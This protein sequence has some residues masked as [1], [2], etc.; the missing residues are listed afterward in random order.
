MV[1]CTSIL[2]QSFF[3]IAIATCTSHEIQIAMSLFKISFYNVLLLEDTYFN[4]GFSIEI[5]VNMIYSYSTVWCAA[6]LIPLFLTVMTR[7]S[8]KGRSIK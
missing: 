3:Y 8:V 6:V 7:D 2:L 5:G 1:Y 4:Y